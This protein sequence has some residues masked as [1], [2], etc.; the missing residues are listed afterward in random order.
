MTL[1][2]ATC[3]SANLNGMKTAIEIVQEPDVRSRLL[4]ALT[5]LTANLYAD[6]YEVLPIIN[7][8]KVWPRISPGDTWHFNGKLMQYP[9]SQL[10]K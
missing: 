6:Y 7:G 2:S 1:E 8:Q 5:R 9:A 4:D 3:I 10:S